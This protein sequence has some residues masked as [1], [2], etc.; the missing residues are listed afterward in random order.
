MSVIIK[1]INESYIQIKNYDKDL[2]IK[3]KDRFVFYAPNYF[4]NPKYRQGIW[5]GRIYLFNQ[6]ND[7]LPIGLFKEAYKTIKSYTNDLVCDLSLFDKGYEISKEEIIKFCE[8]IKVA[9]II[10][11]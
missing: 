10:L 5:D 2:L 7:T 11:K 4:F 8:L 9:N 1:K 6:K 3:L